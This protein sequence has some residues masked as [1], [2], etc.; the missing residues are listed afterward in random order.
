[1]VADSAKIDAIICCAALNRENECTLIPAFFG[2]FILWLIFA[3][4]KQ[5]L[6]LQL[7]DFPRVLFKVRVLLQLLDLLLAHGGARP[8]LPVDPDLTRPRK[9]G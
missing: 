6:L 7:R 4:Q 8:D 9:T 2:G 1:M 5:D 3:Q